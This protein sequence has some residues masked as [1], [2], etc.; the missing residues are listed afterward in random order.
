MPKLL[1]VLFEL[2][3]LR[4]LL[5]ECLK[6]NLFASILQ[7]KTSCLCFT[8]FLVLMNM[9]IET[10]STLHARIH[11]CVLHPID[12]LFHYFAM[13]NSIPRNH[14]PFLLIILTFPFSQLTQP[15]FHSLSIARSLSNSLYLF[16]KPTPIMGYSHSNLGSCAGGTGVAQKSQHFVRQDRVQHQWQ[17]LLHFFS[18]GLY[19]PFMFVS[20]QAA[21]V[22]A[23]S[24]IHPPFSMVHKVSYFFGVCLCPCMWVWV[25]YDSLQASWCNKK[26]HET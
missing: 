18:A 16:H 1:F 25:L 24:L 11:T 13:E 8:F 6:L 12:H 3:E 20:C 9:Y 10:L 14:F 21:S 7:F 19:A 17:Q 15:L 5:H 22:C 2:F 26:K 23:A 4:R